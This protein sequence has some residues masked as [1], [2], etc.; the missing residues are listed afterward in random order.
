M[1]KSHDIAE[2][3]LKPAITATSLL[4]GRCETPL[5]TRHLVDHM[6][7]SANHVLFYLK[8]QVGYKVIYWFKSGC[9]LQPATFPRP[10]AM[11]WAFFIGTPEPPNA[12]V[13]LPSGCRVNWCR[14]NGIT[15][16]G[17]LR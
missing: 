14:S 17:H 12:P 9:R 1:A 3:R 11:L 13:D 8:I 7:T 10:A 5:P 16:K 15:W 4:W 2:N 6:W